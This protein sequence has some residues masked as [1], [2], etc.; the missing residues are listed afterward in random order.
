MNDRNEEN[1]IIEST[2]RSRWHEPERSIEMLRDFLRLHP[3]ATRAKLTLASIFADEYGEDVPG[4]ERLYRE[5]LTRFPENVPA[6]CGLAMLHGRSG[7]SV[8]EEESIRLLTRAAEVSQDIDILSNLA[9]KL[10]DVGRLSEAQRVFEQLLSAAKAKG[11]KHVVRTA[12]QALKAI[13]RGKRPTSLSYSWPS[14]E[15]VGPD[16]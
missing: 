9:H 10:W 14:V 6:L 8:A 3:L 1:R 16:G 7:S 5:V 2:T 13:R 4:A 15:N 11:K 12:E